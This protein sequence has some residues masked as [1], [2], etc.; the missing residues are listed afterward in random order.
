MLQPGTQFG[1]YEIQRLLGRGGMGTVYVAHDPLLGRMVAIKIFLSDLDLPDAAD[2]FAREARAAAALNHANIVT[3]H[4]FGEYSSQP[5]IVME[6][7]PGETLADVVRRKAAVALSEKL[8]WIEDLC[9]GAAYAHQVGV[10][11]RDIKPTNLMIDRSG[12]L[13][14]L[15]FGIARMLGGTPSPSATGV[16]GTPGY[17]A[18]EQIVGGSVDHRADIFA[19][20]VVS[21]ELLSYTEAF[22]GENPHAITH[23]IVSG[24]APP[25]AQAMPS[26]PP[27]LLEAIERA[28]NKEAAE[29]FPDAE[30]MRAAISRVRRTV[31][32]DPGLDA[33]GSPRRGSAQPATNVSRPG[34]GSVRQRRPD[35]AG[36]A[37]LTPPPEPRRPDRELLARR[38]AAQIEASLTEARALLHAGDLDG[39]ME[40]CVQALT[41]DDTHADALDVED[42]IKLAQA[43]QRAALL[44]EEARVELGRGALTSVQGLLQQARELD[45]DAVEARRI[46]RDLRLARVEQERLRHRAR[47]ISAAI[48]S[49]RDALD[50]GRIEAALAFAREARELDASADEPRRLEAEALRRLDEETG[51]GS[52]VEMAEPTVLRVADPPPPVEQAPPTV[53][54]PAARYTPVPTPPAPP[55]PPVVPPPAAKPQ[56]PAAARVK[57]D[58]PAPDVAAMTRQL[59][60]SGRTL[61]DRAVAR[62]KRLSPRDRLIAASAAGAVLLAAVIV[63][64]VVYTPPAVVP[65][66]QIVIEALPWATV[67]EV[68]GEDGTVHPLPTPAATPLLLRLP[69]GTY[70]VR[71]AGPPPAGTTREITVAVTEGA[72]T[73]APVT[74]FLVIT[75]E[76]YFDPYLTETATPADAALDALAGAPAAAPA[77]A[78]PSET[79]R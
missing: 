13:K 36:V 79:P 78:A 18:P 37:E 33:A 59:A 70:T 3:I 74:Q 55:A 62:V 44:L 35:V 30:S 26:A 65:S 68:K 51:S 67:T 16:I 6:Y 10:V 28:L 76:D 2:R 12:R 64:I 14:I 24:D 58:R 52:V 27:E 1:R 48:A 75:P 34:T 45:P 23:R 5:Y 54:L 69:V 41:L 11:H 53:I 15:D 32:E 42:T 19:I 66:G 21:Y 57:K 31:E 29:R 50:E 63:L 61:V 49:A 38:R 72:V 43:K 46:E 77:A 22:P 73:M 4:D 25:L 47:A 71:L 7:V 17:M 60:A 56:A 8:R 20:G 9:A 40:A 39:A